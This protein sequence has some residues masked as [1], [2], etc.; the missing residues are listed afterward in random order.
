[1]LERNDGCEKRLRIGIL[2]WEK[3]SGIDIE[4]QSPLVL[5]EP[6]WNFDL[7]WKIVGA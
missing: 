5:I 2:I 3:E 6:K 1:M 7:A 4:I